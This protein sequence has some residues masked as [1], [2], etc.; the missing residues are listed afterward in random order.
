MTDER[1]STGQKHWPRLIGIVALAITFAWLIYAAIGSNLF[2]SRPFP[3]SI[4]D[5]RILYERSRIVVDRGFYQP[6]EIFPYPPPAVVL[7][8]ITALL[9]YSVAAGLWMII[10]LFAAGA[11]F[12]MGSSLVGMKHHPYRWPVALGALILINYSVVWDLRSQNCNIV[13]CCLLTASLWA[14]QRGRNGPSGFFL[15]AAI[16]LKLYPILVLLYFLWIGRRRAVVNTMLWLGV[17]FVLGPPLVF[18]SHFIQAY[19]TW[20]EMMHHIYVTID[21]SNHPI[22]ISLSFTLTNRL[23][24]DPAQRGWVILA[25]SLIWITAVGFALA[26][27]WQKSAQPREFGWNLA[28]DCGILALA[29]VVIS[30]YFEAYHA[31]P[32]LLPALAVLERCASREMGR[33]QLILVVLALAAGLLALKVAGI[34][35]VRGLGLYIQMLLLVLAVAIVRA[36]GLWR[37]KDLEARSGTPAVND[38]SYPI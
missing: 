2:G 11:T 30:P 15:A 24:L 7:F 21:Q 10:T 3:E 28:A 25:A 8:Y 14:L 16:A 23:K 37:Q 4:V 32:A 6:S 18:R 31:V 33:A 26:T 13:G 9:P 29:P 36:R 19:T 35:G 22:L 12:V 17:F 38:I 34:C 1:V 5:Y 27:G 20:L